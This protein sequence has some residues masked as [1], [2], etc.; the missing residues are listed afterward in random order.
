VPAISPRL[1]GAP[2]ATV[3]C[4]TGGTGPGLAVQVHPQGK[5][6]QSDA[7]EEF[8]ARKVSHVTLNFG[9]VKARK[10]NEA[11]QQVIV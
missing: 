10:G 7:P 6:N 5:T 4:I 8:N 2:C 11:W 9:L 1:F 3:T